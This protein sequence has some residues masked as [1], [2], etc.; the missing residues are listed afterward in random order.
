MWLRQCSKLFP[1]GEYPSFMEILTEHVMKP[2]YDYADEFEYGPRCRPRRPGG[3]RH[4]LDG[5]RG[6]L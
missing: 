5:G 2:G 4:A 1:A 3:A 6:I